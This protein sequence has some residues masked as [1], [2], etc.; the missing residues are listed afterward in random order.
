MSE[1]LRVTAQWEFRDTPPVQCERCASRLVPYLPR[2]Q[3]CQRPA[4]QAVRELAVSP[5]APMGP[6]PEGAVRVAHLS[7]LHVGHFLTAERVQPMA[8]FRIWLERLERAQVGALII[9]GDLVER[10]GDA[11]EMGRVRAMLEASAMDWVVVPGNHDIKRP[12]HHDVFHDIFGAYPRVET[13]QGLD[14]VLLDSM[15][16]LPLE[17]RD[18][19]ERM[20]GDYV[21]YTEGRVGAAQLEQ[22]AAA[23]DPH[24]PRPRLLVLHHHVMRQHADL[25]PLVPRQAGVTEDVFGTMKALMDTDRVFEWAGAHGIHTLCHGHKHQYQQPGVRA[26]NLLVLNAGS[27]TLRPGHQ[28]GRVLDVFE[29]RRVVSNLEM[30]L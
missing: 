8:I 11:Y 18:V 24:R 25:M 20:Y 29:D 28:L 12:G 26:G 23:L 5:G 7:D 10:P 21:C 3:V 1:T 2:C 6:P 17:E 22:V 15:A 13:V 4:P 27:S 9:S 14:F 19:A 30:P 16:G